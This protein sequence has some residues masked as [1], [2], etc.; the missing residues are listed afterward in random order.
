[1]SGPEFFDAEHL[2]S[3]T[4]EEEFLVLSNGP[5][6]V[7][8]GNKFQF[9]YYLDHEVDP[10]VHKHHIWID[11]VRRAQGREF[12]RVEL[13]GSFGRGGLKDRDLEDMVRTRVKSR[14]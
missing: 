10:R 5:V 12:G 3:P 7:L 13:V 2:R 14:E 1:M 8:A 9:D 11:D 4:F 6:A